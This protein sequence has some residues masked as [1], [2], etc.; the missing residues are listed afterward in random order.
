[1]TGAG[2]I[3]ESL[4]RGQPFE[5]HVVGDGPTVGYLHGTLGV[6]SAVP[7]LTATASTGLTVVA[8]SLPGF[9][10]SEPCSDL[11]TL[12]DWVCAASEVLDLVAVSGKPCVASSIGA[13]LALEVAAVRP[14]AF[15]ELVLVAP[16][17]LWDDAQ[18]V[19]DPFGVTLGV[20]RELLTVD[21]EKTATFF[22]ND[23]SLDAD[24][25]ISET[26]QQYQARSTAA[27]LIWPIP[28]FG[29][30]SRIHRVT[31]P[32]TLIWGAQDAIIPVDY[33]ERFASLL[34]NV[35]GAHIIEDAG[36]LVEI[37]RPDEVAQIVSKAFNR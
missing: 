9:G 23:P 5:S 3:S 2:V 12:F 10:S 28:E 29:L 18:P 30:S 25:K 31:C 33:L 35:V 32:V 8:P 14:D 7:F 21:V 26:V 24:G 16:F 27:S 13:M 1:M 11:R 15:E 34:P 19:A 37:D 36:H 17:G 22:E 4:F 6:A 20:Q